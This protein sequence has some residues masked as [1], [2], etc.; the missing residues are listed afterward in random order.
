[1]VE[2]PRFRD[3]TIEGPISEWYKVA[4]HV[5]WRNIAEVKSAYPHADFVN[6]F[7]VFNI[8]RPL[9]FARKD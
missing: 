2:E 7:T 6:P 9:P 8:R 3:G 4:T 1:M 5:T